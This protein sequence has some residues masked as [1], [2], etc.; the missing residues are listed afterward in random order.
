M[1]VEQSYMIR[2]GNVKKCSF[3]WVIAP[4]KYGCE[5]V[6][7]AGGFNKRYSKLNFG[8]EVALFFVFETVFSCKI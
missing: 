8:H 6:E 1:D 7:W 4:P 5:V 3:D 2:G